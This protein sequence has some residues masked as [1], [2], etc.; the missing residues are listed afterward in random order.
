MEAFVEPES[1][2]TVLLEG[3]HEDVD[4]VVSSEKVLVRVDEVVGELVAQ[5]VHVLCREDGSSEEVVDTM[6]SALQRQAALP[7]E[8]NLLHRHC[9][10]YS[11]PSNHHKVS[12]KKHLC[13]S[14]LHQLIKRFSTVSHCT[15]LRY[16]RQH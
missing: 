14:C 8:V 5:L 4:V 7:L 16:S 11:I 10:I 13:P 3:Q 6:P 15:R 9:Y 1:V 12:L 2:E